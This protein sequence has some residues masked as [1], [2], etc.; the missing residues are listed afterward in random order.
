[1]SRRPKLFASLCAVILFSVAF[2][3]A[4]GPARAA[5]KRPI[6]V[7]PVST[8][9]MKKAIAAHKGQVTVV[10]FWAT[11]CGP[12]VAEFPDLVKLANNYAGKGVAV[13]SVSAN[14]VSE[15]KKDV[16]P[17]LTKQKANFENY[18]IKE[19]DPDVFINSFDPK[20]QGD[21][22]RTFVYDKTGKLTAE[23]TGMQTYSSFS[24]AVEKA[25]KK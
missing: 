14:D 13:M 24:A 10:N 9:V 15:I 8:S 16:L 4:P 2:G 7:S 22:P 11:W 12:C 23:L 20:W 6:A 18:L 3:L 17:F 5:S 19:S 21:I 25:L 1:M